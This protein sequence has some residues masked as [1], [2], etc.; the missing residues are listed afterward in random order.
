[1]AGRPPKFA[2]ASAPITVTL[3]LRTLE[4]LRHIDQDRAKAIVKCADTVVATALADRKRVEIIKVVEGSGLIIIGPCPSLHKLPGLRLVEIAP[5]RFL[6]V[7]MQGYS[8]HALELDIIDII[9][10]LA[11]EEDEERALLSELRHELSFHRRQESMVSGEILF[12]DA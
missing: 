11:P 7:I 5:L 2:E 9:D 4:S 10:K 6:L 12:V 3:P 1:M 8:P